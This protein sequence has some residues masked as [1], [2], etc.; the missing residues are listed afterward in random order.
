[1][2]SH[3]EAI[4]V[5]W[6]IVLLDCLLS[7]ELLARIVHVW[8]IMKEACIHVQDVQRFIGF[9]SK[10]NLTSGMMHTSKLFGTT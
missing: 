3:L 10:C 6:N 9:W 1:M 7:A 4:E 2:Q 5:H 8:L